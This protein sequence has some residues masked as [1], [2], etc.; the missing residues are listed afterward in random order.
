M[1]NSDPARAKRPSRR[2]AIAAEKL[3]E[4]KN[5]SRSIGWLHR[6]SQTMNAARVAKAPIPATTTLAEVQPRVGASMIAH[7]SSPIPTIESSAPAGSG[8]SA[9]G[10]RDSGTSRHAAIT[11]MISSGT[12]TRN[13]EPHQNLDSN[14]PPA[15]GPSAIPTPIVPPHTPIARA[16]LL[17]SGNTLSRIERPA[18]IVIAAP[19]PI[20]ARQAISTPTEPDSA[21][22]SDPTANVQKPAS[23]IRLRPI[24][25]ARLP[26]T[27]SRPP[28]PMA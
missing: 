17:G 21:A 5:L 3:R 26:A 28:K 12:L 24:R 22:P 10:L 6:R 20:A 27:S 23:S 7:R 11:P 1:T 16:R 14:S 4:W 18:G 19:I 25:S 15:S 13:T 2:A 8:R 9:A